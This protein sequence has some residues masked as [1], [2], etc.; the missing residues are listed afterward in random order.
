MK[1]VA[2]NNIRR[3]KEKA[4]FWYPYEY[5]MLEEVGVIQGQLKS[6]QNT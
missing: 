3:G 6:G 2:F 1:A 5:W 4:R